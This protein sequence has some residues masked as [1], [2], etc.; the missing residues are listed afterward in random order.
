M[1]QIVN[2]TCEYLP[3]PLGLDTP[4]P[5]FGW[6]MESDGRA[7][8]QKAYR[9][10]VAS[11]PQRL[12]AGE[13][14][15][16]DSGRV[17]SD[18]QVHVEYAGA[19]L[20]SAQQCWWSVTVWAA[21]DGAAIEEASSPPARFEMGLLDESDWQGRWIAAAADIHAPLLRKVFTLATP[22]AAARAYVCGL[23]W[24]ELYIN[25]RRVGEQVLDPAMTNYDK[26]SLYVTHDV[27]DLLHE[28]VNVVGVILGHGWF[29]EP[30]F[31][32]GGVYPPQIHYGPC[33]QLLLQLNVADANG[34]AAS[35]VSDESWKTAPSPI[36]SADLFGGETYDA[37][38][39]QRGW[40][41]D[42]FD[43]SAW[44]PVRIVE[45]RTQK[46]SAQVLPPLRVMETYRP[47]RL[48]CPAPGTYIYHF[49]KYFGGW[50]RLRVKAPAGT[51]VTIKYSG[52]LYNEGCELDGQLD[53]RSY[54]EPRETDYYI[55]RGDPNGEV[56][57]PRFTFHP[58]RF[59]QVSGLPHPP[60]LA[61][62]EGCFVH[63]DYDFSAD[64]ACS[65][66]LLNGIH[67]LCRQTLRIAAFGM[68]LDCLCREHWAF[69][70]P[71]SVSS[72]L[73]ARFYQPLFWEKWMRDAADAQNDDGS[74]IC[75]VP[76]YQDA[77][78]GDPAWA[79][80]YPIAVWHSYMA[81]GDRRLLEEHYEPM[82]R[83]LD[84][85]ATRAT[86][87]A[88]SGGSLGD[89]MV[90]GPE[91]EKEEFLSSETPPEPLWTGYYYR[92][93]DIMQRVAALL[94]KPAD[95]ARFAA[96]AQSARDALNRNWLDAA[97]GRYA[98]GSQTSNLVP[99]ALEVVPAEHRPAVVADI[100]D[101]IVNKHG[102]HLHTGTCGTPAM[103]EAL[104]R[105][106]AGEVMF[107]VMTQTTYPGWGFMVARRA[108]TVWESW[109]RYMWDRLG[110][111]AESMPM[112]AS[113]SGFFFSDI[114]GIGGPGY[115]GADLC[116]AGYAHVQIAP[117]VLGD[118]TWARASVPTPRGRIVSS[119]CRTAAGL[120]LEVVIPPGA[121]AAITVPTLGIAN[122]VIREGGQ[123]VWK[124]GAFIAGVAGLEKAE[125]AG[126]GVC[127]AAGSGRYLFDVSAGS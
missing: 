45:A 24:H 70:D 48:A 35:V 54:P 68:L 61:D 15:L 51:K 63:G 64:F 39:E 4:R 120:H 12:A 7:I 59:V 58:V 73:M 20:R 25:G 67:G 13:A 87:G 10:R 121:T 116:T 57:E 37:R 91:A 102:G 97:A 11:T 65:N 71:A 2:A 88:V 118:L 60:E 123:E 36:V 29:S 106:G 78:P 96:M 26:R 77:K 86:D 103:I 72:A 93:A 110:K 115:F 38:I 17:E 109:G 76:R 23:G 126:S 9:V 99:L 107:G 81:Y 85:L 50:V 82:T 98:T 119:W 3:S 114:A 47:V 111:R 32:P 16:W 27:T 31:A 92:C 69:L 105:A 74:I 95:A 66:E 14:N 19:E 117:Q 125:P 46:L 21:G 40:A 101:N 90:P 5:R 33:P 34:S 112:W 1:L 44:A 22:P 56:F 89:H 49:E 75:V 18:R 8:A 80:N 62:M 83:F 28:G 84:H 100:V 6:G 43:D 124:N 30:E 42:G 104:A 41:Q 55:C 79:G 113:A 94:G 122:A 52:L 53:L 108:T 127:F